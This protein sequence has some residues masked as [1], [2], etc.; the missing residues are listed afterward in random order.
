MI[1]QLTQRYSCVFSSLQNKLRLHEL[2]KYFL[3]PPGSEM[4][5]TRGDKNIP[6]VL[7]PIIDSSIAAITKTFFGRVQDLHIVFT[8]IISS[9]EQR[10]RA[11]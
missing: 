7:V 8:R 6:W 3:G 1:L 9:E 5:M 11:G 10:E 2:Q 4:F